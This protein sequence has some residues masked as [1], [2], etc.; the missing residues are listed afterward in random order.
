MAR[1]NM[2]TTHDYLINASLPMATDSYT[3]I[4][5]KAIIDKTRE[6]LTNKGFIIDKEMY[7]CSEGA[8]V[9]QGIYYLKFG[10]DPDMSMLFAW[11]NSYDKSTKFKCSVGAYIHVSLASII[12][13]N[14]TT[15]NRKH[16]G[17]ADQEAFDVIVD[18]IT[19]AESYFKQLVS[20]KERM[21]LI[22]ITEEK[23]AEIIGRLYLVNELISSEQL[24]LI[25]NEFRKPSFSYSEF[26]HEN[27]V[28]NMYNIVIY[29]LQ[30][31]HPKTWMDQQSLTHWFICN[32]FF[33]DEMGVLMENS[34]APVESTIA[35]PN[36]IDLI[37]MIKDVESE[38]LGKHAEM[39]IAMEKFTPA[40]VKLMEEMTEEIESRRVEPSEMLSGVNNDN[41]E[42]KLN[43]PK[44][45]S[46]IAKISDK[47][48]ILP[49]DTIIDSDMAAVFKRDK[50][51]LMPIALKEAEKI[52]L[53]HSEEA[54]I[55]PKKPETISPNPALEIEPSTAEPRDETE[56]F[57]WICQGCGNLQSPTDIY[58]EGQLCTTCYNLA[59]A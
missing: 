35:N 5:H 4:S 58:N 25:K 43:T 19:N 28:W 6:C 2:F 33:P 31:S 3:V 7:K 21:K 29:A 56:D 26:G 48:P 18:H 54:G 51:V 57:H 11:T 45:K 27:S 40:E 17:T 23:R 24:A 39:P 10:S 34:G 9:A 22:D 53:Q 50:E 42:V 37:D 49:L 13:T 36:Q 30:R 46:H 47:K 20:D 55:M 59:H 14:M 12:G 41:A 16:T 32:M 15:F 38:T 8:Q 44:D 52:N 1:R